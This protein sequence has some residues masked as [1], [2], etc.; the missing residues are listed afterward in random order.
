VLAKIAAA[1]RFNQVT[2]GVDA[3]TGFS[4]SLDH[5]GEPA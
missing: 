1:E 4:V 2:L 5:V 3:R